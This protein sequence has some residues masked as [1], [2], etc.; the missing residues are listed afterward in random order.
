MKKFL[1][2]P[3]VLASLLF[4]SGALAS[5]PASFT[6]TAEVCLTVGP[7]PV[8]EAAPPRGVPP[9]L[10]GEELAGAVTTSSG[11]PEP[12][13]SG[14]VVLV[15]IDHETVLVD[16]VE[17]TFSARVAGQLTVTIG[18]DSFSGTH[19]GNVT[20]DFLDPLD[21]IGTIESSTA[22]IRWQ[23]GGD[24]VQARGTAVGEF[25]TTAGA[26]LDCPGGAS[27]FGG[28]L[29]LTGKVHTR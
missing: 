26:G 22:I 5:Q 24:G 20:G 9:V 6:A 21:I 23:L 13:L 8:T 3:F 29:E 15:T 18:D 10:V 17:G 16:F 1:F 7:D 11:W 25:S 2:V 4:P 27:A 19:S 12:G 14:A 28:T